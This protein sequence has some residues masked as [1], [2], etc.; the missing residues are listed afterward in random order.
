M[1]KKELL[2]IE[3]WHFLNNDKEKK[4]KNWRI[5]WVLSRL[6]RDRCAT[7]L[8]VLDWQRVRRLFRAPRRAWCK[9]SPG[10]LHK[11][12]NVCYEVAYVELW[13]G[14]VTR[15]YG[16][17]SETRQKKQSAERLRVLMN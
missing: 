3:F 4:L 1:W 15:Y 2:K 11:N 16:L 13:V 14:R 5:E 6:D 17:C 7:R 10:S 8:R 9:R 12:R